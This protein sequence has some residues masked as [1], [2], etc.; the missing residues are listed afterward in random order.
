MV[1]SQNL[2]CPLKALLLPP[3]SHLCASM[4][5]KMIKRWFLFPFSHLSFCLGAYK[6]RVGFQGD[7]IKW[8]EWNFIRDLSKGKEVE[9]DETEF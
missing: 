6:S 7:L 5:L 9:K 8:L 3:E 2:D 4:A 1:F